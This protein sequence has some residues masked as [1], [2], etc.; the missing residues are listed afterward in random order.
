MSPHALL[1]RQTESSESSLP[2]SFNDFSF[3]TITSD[4]TGFV[5]V[6]CLF[7]SSAKLICVVIYLVQTRKNGNCWLEAIRC[8]LGIK[9]PDTMQHPSF[10]NRLLRRF[11]VMCLVK[12]AKRILESRRIFLAAT[13]GSADK[14]VSVGPFTYRSYC[15]Y[16]LQHG[17]W[18][19]DC[20]LYALALET[21]LAIMV[22]LAK[23][24][25]L[26]PITH[27]FTLY[28]ADIVLVHNEID[29]FSGTGK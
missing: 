28:Q 8:Q 11:V 13:Y 18:G 24:L 16:I 23:S 17:T 5:V 21:G 27:N 7:S 4:D 15:R 9:Q 26:Y 14:E 22:L 20:V 3:R 29:H 12:R 2:M 25:F 10:P 6:R 1:G 19:D